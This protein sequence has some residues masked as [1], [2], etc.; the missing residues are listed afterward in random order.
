[1]PLQSVVSAFKNTEGMSFD[2]DFSQS[3]QTDTQALQTYIDKI[4]QN[5]SHQDAM[6]LS[7]A[8]A[9][10]KAVEQAQAL[11]G[12]STSV[13]K[14]GNYV[15][16]FAMKQKLAEVSVIATD[17][18]LRNCSSIINEYNSGLNTTNNICKNTGLAQSQLVDAVGASNQVMGNYLTKMGGAPATM[19]G[20]A[21]ALIGAKLQT[22]GLQA[23]SMALNAAI[24]MGIGL[25]ISAAIK[26]ISELIH[27]E[28]NLIQK[29]DDA[30]N[31]IKSIGDS[32]KSAKN[33]V[34]EC[35]DSFIKLSKGV[36]SVT[37]KNL[38]LSNDDYQEFLNISNQLA[39]TFPTLTRHYDENG[40]AIV[41]LNGDAE[42][43]TSTL[44]NLL[45]TE[46]ALAN[47]EIVDNLPDL[48]K[49]IKVKSDQYSEE[50]DEYN[51]VI[52]GLSDFKNKIDNNPALLFNL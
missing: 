21:K 12:V 36:D 49:G 15:N 8:G 39:E 24:G 29:S 27:Y 11:E 51:N 10:Q 22:I 26:L 25:A 42:T 44:Q 50:I 9:S 52:D 18:S 37:G 30:A 45:E 16:D 1:M 47:Q 6:A 40:N 34:D 3:L 14:S 7:M 38:T 46:R 4:K 48:Y 35:T 41:Q 17:K 23:A 32:Y 5:K 28:E 20:Y 2:T 43:I 31:T 13:L 19:N 33:T